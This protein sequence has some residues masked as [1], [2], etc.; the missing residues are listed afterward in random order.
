MLESELP[1]CTVAVWLPG[2]LVLPP[3]SRNATF[4]LFRHSVKYFYH[5]TIQLPARLP[6]ITEEFDARVGERSGTGQIKSS[7]ISAIAAK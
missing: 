7:F 1:L 5:F 2:A 3:E 4:L 6:V